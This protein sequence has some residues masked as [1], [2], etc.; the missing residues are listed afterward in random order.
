VNAGPLRANQKRGHS[1]TMEIPQEGAE[2]SLKGRKSPEEASGKKKENFKDETGTHGK[3]G[4]GKLGRRRKPGAVLVCLER[5]EKRL[6]R[7]RG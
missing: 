6:M 2:K 3:G 4:G 1:G 7:E 5:G